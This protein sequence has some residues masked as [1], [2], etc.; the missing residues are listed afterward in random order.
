MSDTRP[1]FLMVSGWGFP[2]SAWTPA[3]RALEETAELRVLYAGDLLRAPVAAGALEGHLEAGR[4]LYLGGWSL[5][6]MLVLEHASGLGGVL[7]GIML[8]ASTPRFCADPRQ[9]WGADPEEIRAM[10]KNLQRDPETVLTAFYRRS[11]HPHEVDPDASQHWLR[12]S[13][14]HLGDLIAGLNYLVDADL[15]AGTGLRGVPVHLLHGRRDAIVPFA[16]SRSLAV[17]LMPSRL[18]I[19]PDAGHDLPLRRP[20]LLRAAFSRL[21]AMTR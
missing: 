10:R 18:D 11:A 6:G 7:S 3:V 2:P 19:V 16:A 5:G 20:D 17:D 12:D 21:V 15:R 1:L 9:P 4:S 13:V 8:I 14:A